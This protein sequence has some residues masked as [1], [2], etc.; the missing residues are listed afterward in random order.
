LTSNTATNSHA[1]TPAPAPASASS[2]PSPL[3]QVATQDASAAPA[4]D[5]FAPAI[6]FDH[7]S[8]WW[9]RLANILLGR[10]RLRAQ[11]KV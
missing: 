6:K 7:T 10:R 5:L 8:P 3:P 2:S 9:F 4:P 1:P 11:R